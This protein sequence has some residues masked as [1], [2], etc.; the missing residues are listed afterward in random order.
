MDI[1]HFSAGSSTFLTA[2]W[3]S[4]FMSTSRQ[5][6]QSCAGVFRRKTEITNYLF[7]SFLQIFESDPKLSHLDQQSEKGWTFRSFKNKYVCLIMTGVWHSF[8]SFVSLFCE[9]FYCT[10]VLQIVCISSRHSDGRFAYLTLCLV[11][12][13]K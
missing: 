11:L 7:W 10:N 6:F 8:Q 2:C 5:R 12:V 1:S 9:I 3:L 4:I 13:T